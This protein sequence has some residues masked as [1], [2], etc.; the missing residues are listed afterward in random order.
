MAI[1]AAE[2]ENKRSPLNMRTTA[3]LRSALEQEASKA[4]RSLAQEVEARLERSFENDM[5]LSAFIG[6]TTHVQMLMRVV[7]ATIN[8]I[9]EYRGDRY[10]DSYA[11]RWHCRKGVEEILDTIFGP[12]FGEPKPDDGGEWTEDQRKILHA[13]AR[14]IANETLKDFGFVRDMPGHVTTLYQARTA[15]RKAQDAASGSQGEAK[16]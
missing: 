10:V 3:K 12:D 4:D 15:V 13:T 6:G 7:A 5:L 11:T 16:K 9:E 2:R 1:K 14:K 8:N